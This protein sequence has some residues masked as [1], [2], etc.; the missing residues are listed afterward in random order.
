MTPLITYRLGQIADVQQGYTFKPDYQGQS[1][2]EWAYVKVADIGSPTSS[3]YLRKSLN[4]VSSEVLR[5]MRATPFPAG[6]IVFPR[7]GAALRNNNKRILAEDCLT[8]DNVLVVTVR[9]ANVCDPEYLYYWFDFHDLQ[10]FCNS[11]T[12]PVING[13]NL[14]LQEVP[15]PD[16]QLQRRTASVLSAWDT[17]IE[18][19]ER[20]IAAK[21]RFHRWLQQRLIEQR[22]ARHHWETQEL[23]GLIRERSERSIQHDEYPVLTSSRRGLFL[24]SEY[25][26]K[27]VTSEDN[28][29]YKIMRRGDFTFRSMSDDGRFVFNRL[30]KYDTGIISPAYGVF[31]A[32]GVCPEFLAHYLNSNYFA[33][34][35]ARETQ[36]GTRKALRF[37]A[38]ASMEVELPKRADQERIA[39]IL[40]E[41]HREIDLLQTQLEILRRQKRGLMQKL[42]TGVWRVP[43]PEEITG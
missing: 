3:K 5:E 14:K 12:V 33:Q 17:A 22:A 13:R 19:T 23:G 24:Q 15:L 41:S 34:L 7:V 21:E 42:L 32:E 2:G 29:G 36:G 38:L 28:T 37:S 35:L 39:A 18:T 4:Y 9:D 8:D 11:G 40:N 27:Q 10:D 43:V 1:C 20:L 26:S 6:S 16:I 31:Y 25:F 30:E